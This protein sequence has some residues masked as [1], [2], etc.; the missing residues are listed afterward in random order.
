MTD[1]QAFRFNEREGEDTPNHLFT[2]WMHSPRPLGGFFV[3]EVA[4]LL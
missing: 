1:E 3:E 2:V 4:S